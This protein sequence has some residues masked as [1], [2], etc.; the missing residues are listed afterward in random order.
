[1]FELVD[2]SCHCERSAVISV[3]GSSVGIASA[4]QNQPRNDSE[5]K[6]GWWIRKGA[7][8]SRPLSGIQES[9]ITLDGS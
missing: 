9:V 6:V 3:P 1:M 4:D 7:T 2:P 8:L 5:Q